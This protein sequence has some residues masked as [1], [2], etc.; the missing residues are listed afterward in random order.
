MSSRD[1]QRIW[2]RL[3]SRDDDP[4]RMLDPKRQ[5]SKPWG[6]T[7]YGRCA[8]CAGEGETVHECES[9]RERVDAN[10]PHAEGEARYWAECPACAE[11]GEGRRI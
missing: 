2:F 7:V 5:R 8:K 10:C 4:Q 1:D 3:H 9:C 6:G 11:S